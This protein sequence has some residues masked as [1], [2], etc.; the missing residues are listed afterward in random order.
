MGAEVFGEDVKGPCPALEYEHGRTWCGLIRHPRKY[1]GL[2]FDMPEELEQ[3][4][5]TGVKDVNG[6][7]E[8]CQMKDESAK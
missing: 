6:V 2:P 5:A 7:G 4:F 3:F 1:L 8:G